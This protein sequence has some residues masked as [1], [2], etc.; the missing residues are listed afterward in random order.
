MIVY[1]T[2]SLSLSLRMRSFLE[3][4]RYRL[5]KAETAKKSFQSLTP[6]P[7]SHHPPVETPALQF[8]LRSMVFMEF[9]RGHTR[10]LNAFKSGI[11]F[12]RVRERARER[13]RESERDKKE[14]AGEQAGER[15]RDW[16]RKPSLQKLT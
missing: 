16:G 8:S 11:F 5:Y 7:S 3:A 2:L 10:P 1:Q 15:E 9:V 13:E 6:S 4:P 12:V 14:R